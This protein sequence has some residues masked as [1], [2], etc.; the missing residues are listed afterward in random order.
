MH[1]LN[2][3]NYPEIDCHLWLSQWANVL[4]SVWFLVRQLSNYQLGTAHSRQF[5][6]LLF[7]KSI[8]FKGQRWQDFH[9]GNLMSW[10]HDYFESWTGYDWTT[11]RGAVFIIIGRFCGKE[12]LL[13]FSLGIALV[14]VVAAVHLQLQL[15]MKL[16]LEKSQKTEQHN[17]NRLL[18]YLSSPTLSLAIGQAKQ[19]LGGRSVGSVP[20]FPLGP[21]TCVHCT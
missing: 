14:Q 16:V 8:N 18:V 2:I 12:I 3:K 21:W 19:L 20:H 10:S 17:Q 11:S 7:F 5:W 1:N 4:P 13:Y 6:D 9:S 15:F